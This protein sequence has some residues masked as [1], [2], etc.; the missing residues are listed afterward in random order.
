MRWLGNAHWKGEMRRRTLLTVLTALLCV[1][2]LAAVLGVALNFRGES[3]L[4][5]TPSPLDQSPARVKHGEYLAK[6]GNCASC[7]TAR[8]GAAYAGGDALPTPFGRVYGSNL[9]SHRE[10]GIGAWTADHFWR[11]MHHGRSKDG[12]VL[13]PAFPYTSY[14]QVTRQD[15]DALLAYFLSLPPVAQPNKPHE[16]RTPFDSQLAIGV[17]RALFFRAQ[18][19][20]PAPA[21]SA[22]WN[23]GAYLVRGLGH[24]AECHSARNAMGSLK[25]AQ[26]LGGGMMPGHGWYA[27]SLTDAKEGSIAGWPVEQAV[28]LL[29]Y[30]LAQPGAAGVASPASAATTVGPMAEVVSRSM[31][32]WSSADLRATAVYLQSL[33]TTQSRVLAEQ[34]DDNKLKAGEA[35]YGKHCAQCHGDNGQGARTPE[36]AHAYP[37]LAGN[38]AI[39]LANSANVVQVT[40]RG[41]YAPATAGNPQPYGMPPFGYVLS[42]AEVAAV[43]TY[44]RNAWG[45]RAM[46]VTQ[47]EVLRARES[48]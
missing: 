39:T 37:A 20:V 11:A 41:G 1:G 6:V 27:P 42:D 12:R 7:H 48:Q 45:N 35:V 26:A 46:P 4:P 28:A 18:P 14:T 38:R 3:A 34:P 31:Q 24:C 25:D 5:A 17:W 13:T 43:T 32:H 22:E 30:G 21:Q 29:Q 8:G 16:L 44:I 40:L 33:P 10:H 9:T 47:F 2:A 19:F 15:A 36:G 23:R